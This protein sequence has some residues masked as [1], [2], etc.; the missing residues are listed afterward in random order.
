MGKHGH[1]TRR[2]GQSI[3]YRSWNN[4]VQRCTNP[5]RVDFQDRYKDVPIHKG[6]LGVRGFE[7]FLADVGKRPSKRH[8]LDRID[9]CRGYE[10][11]NVR[12]ATLLVQNRNKKW[13]VL[14]RPSDEVEGT[15]SDF[16]YELKITPGAVRKR[17]ERGW[18][19]ERA[20]SQPGRRR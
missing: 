15:T 12:W 3:T 18:D 10:P 16:G 7:T 14:V 5:N 13:R 8:S 11:G 9:P 4:M 2:G 20:L 19:I 17:L 1:A 6:W